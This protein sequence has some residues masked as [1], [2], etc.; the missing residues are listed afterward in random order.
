MPAPIAP[1]SAPVLAEPLSQAAQPAAG[2][3][4]QDA[5]ASAVQSVESFG[6]NANASVERLLSGEGEELHTTI[7]ATQQAEL[8]F[9]LFMQ[10]RNK[11]VSAYQ[12]IMRMQM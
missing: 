8:S 10:M 11:V 3:S 4:F 6:Q 12:E 7:L 1:I 2:A 9:D 5:F